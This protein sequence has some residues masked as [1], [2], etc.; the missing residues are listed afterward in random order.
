MKECCNTG[1]LKKK[2]VKFD[3]SHGGCIHTDYDGYACLALAFEDVIVHMVGG[4]PAHGMCEMYSP[5]GT[6]MI[7]NFEHCPKCGQELRWSEF[8]GER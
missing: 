5:S 1:K 8:T 2:L 7:Y 3:Y 4:D 6:Y